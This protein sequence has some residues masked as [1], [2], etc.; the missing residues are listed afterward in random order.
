[1]TQLLLTRNELEA[2][3]GTRQPKRMAGWLVARGWFFEPAARCGDVPKVDRAYYLARM[4][5][6]KPSPHR[7]GPALDFMLTPS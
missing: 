1:V 6:Q 3:T 7:K 4:S 2:L 5:G